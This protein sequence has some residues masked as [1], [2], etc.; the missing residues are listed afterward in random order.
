[1]FLFN[2]GL[3]GKRWWMKVCVCPNHPPTSYHLDITECGQYV[4]S[5]PR[6]LSTRVFRSTF[7]MGILHHGLLIT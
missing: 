2:K 4:S 1:M 5:Q 7:V 3:T 6:I